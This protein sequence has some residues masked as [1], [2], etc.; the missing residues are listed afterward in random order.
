MSKKILIVGGV[1]GGATA[2]TRLRRL[3]ESAEIVVFER[4]PHVSFSNCSLPFHLSGEIEN[5]ESLILQDPKKLYAQYRLDMRVFNEVTSIDRDKKEVHVKNVQTGEEYSESYD[6]LILSPGASPIVPPFEG[7]DEVNLF[8]M[9]NVGDVVSLKSFIEEKDAKKITVIGGGFIGIEVA[10]NLRLAGYE[11][12]IVEALEQIMKP[13]DYD[14]VQILH[15]EIYD[16][17]IDLIVGDKVAKFEKNTV[18]L[19]SNKKI[20]SDAVVM[21]IGVRPETKL[22]EDAGL[23]IGETRS[24]KV[25]QSYRT[26][27]KD[28]YAVGDA[29]EVYNSLL[30]SQSRLALGGPAQRQARAAADHIYGKSVNNPGVIGSSVIKIFDYNAASTGLTEGLIEATNLQIEYDYVRLIIED[31]VGIMPDK[32]AIHLKVIF[33][34]PTGRILGAQAIGK[35]AADK[36]IDVIATMIQFNARLEDLKEAELTYAP[37]FNNA[38]GVINQAGMV[39][40]NI[41]ESVFKQVPVT[42]ARELVENDAYIIDVRTPE[43]HAMGHLKNAINIPVAEMRDRYDEIPKDRP[44]YMHCTIGQKCYGIISALQQLGFDNIYN[45]S[46]GFAGISFYEYFNDKTQ[47]RDP[48]LTEYLY[49]KLP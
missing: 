33:E 9:R 25:D 11:V 8:T 18:V 7:I 36:R 1:G 24:I 4:G 42:M 39:G 35:G 49:I 16:K 14:M 27:D 19:D 17:G 23:E 30:Q 34:V 47:N 2:A 26:S 29:I 10:E 6:K 32:E 5:H 41:L 13:F 21:A 38:R 12:T 46:G 48:I 31:R 45:I 28:I 15:K 40:L 20:E 43:S 44:V 3:D 22:A 37:P